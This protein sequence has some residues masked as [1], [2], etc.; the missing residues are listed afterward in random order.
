MMGTFAALESRSLVELPPQG[1]T[2]GQ[3]STVS[4]IR[5]AKGFEVF[6]PLYSAAHRWRDRSKE[7]LLPLFLGY[8]FLR[9]G[10]KRRLA[11]TFPSEKELL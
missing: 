3:F 10:L 5:R 6:L 9:G 1:L 11:R 7:L 8:V 2:F 4:T